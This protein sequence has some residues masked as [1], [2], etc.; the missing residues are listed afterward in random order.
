MF[1]EIDLR[2]FKNVCKSSTTIL[3]IG[4]CRKFQPH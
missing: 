2:M 1:Y 4:F 3:Q